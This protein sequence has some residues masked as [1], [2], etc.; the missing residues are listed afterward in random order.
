MP[1]QTYIIWRSGQVLKFRQGGVLR[2]IDWTMQRER[3][4]QGLLARWTEQLPDVEDVDVQ[5]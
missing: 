5:P 1:K 4:L 2:E 3:E